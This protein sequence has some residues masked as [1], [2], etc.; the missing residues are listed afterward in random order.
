VTEDGVRV[1]NR[2]MYLMLQALQTTLTE[3]KLTGE[4]TSK[5][6]TDLA[7]SIGKTTDDHE[8]RIRALEVARWKMAGAGAAL[9]AVAGVLVN[10]AGHL[11]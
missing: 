3:V 1:T 2:D 5:R 6:V 8:A 7:A 4:E 11:V 10:I 9:G